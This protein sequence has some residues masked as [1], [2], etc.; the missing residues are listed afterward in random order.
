MIVNSI[1]PS[2]WRIN[3]TDDQ[4]VVTN[5]VESYK[6]STVFAANSF[7]QIAKKCD[8]PD[9]LISSYYSSDLVFNRDGISISYDISFQDVKVARVENCELKSI[10]LP[11]IIWI[12]FGGP[13]LM[14]LMKRFWYGEKYAD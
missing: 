11:L 7:L 10:N 12:G 9:Y 13:K 6:F 4:F 8:S 1:E 14:R 5:Q 3:N 2:K